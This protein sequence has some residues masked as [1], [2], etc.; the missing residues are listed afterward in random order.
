[1]FLLGDTNFPSTAAAADAAR[2]KRL[3]DDDGVFKDIPITTEPSNTTL[4][5]TSSFL[6][7]MENE[8]QDYFLRWSGLE[9]KKSSGLLKDILQYL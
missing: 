5:S 3:F 6:G 7:G 9:A 1:V 4:I 8:R 2:S